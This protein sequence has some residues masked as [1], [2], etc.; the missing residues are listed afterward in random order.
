MAIVDRE[1]PRHIPVT[2][3]KEKPQPPSLVYVQV[4]YKQMF[5]E[6][7]T[8]SELALH[9]PVT[10]SCS[11][12]QHVLFEPGIMLSTSLVFLI[13]TLTPI[14]PT[15]RLLNKMKTGPRTT[16][17]SILLPLPAS[18]LLKLLG[19]TINLC[20]PS[21][22]QPADGESSKSNH[23]SPSISGDCHS[24]LIALSL[25]DGTPAPLPANYRATEGMPSSSFPRIW[26]AG[27]IICPLLRS[28]SASA[29]AQD[30]HHPSPSSNSLGSSPASDYLL[31]SLLTGLLSRLPAEHVE[32]QCHCCESSDV[33]LEL[34]ASFRSSELIR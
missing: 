27:S 14:S 2:N 28:V 19:K 26:Q 16:C 33:P 29:A 9:S 8:I 13:N 3:W 25:A 22:F 4:F 15:D 6:L 32:E 17:F 23:I 12:N 7:Q 20:W 1:K 21:A 24:G 18:Y 5:K 11:S 34:T 30:H 10:G 31:S